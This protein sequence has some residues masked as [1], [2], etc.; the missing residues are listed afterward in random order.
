MSRN[1]YELSRQGKLWTCYK[2]VTPASWLCQTSYAANG[3]TPSLIL[4]K[5]VAAGTGN[6]TAP[7]RLDISQTGTVAGG[8]ITCVIKTD[9]IDRLSGTTG[10]LWSMG[11]RRRNILVGVQP[12]FTLRDGATA[13]AE[14]AGGADPR[15]IFEGTIFQTVTG[16]GTNWVYDFDE[17]DQLD[18]VGSI[19]VYFYASGTAPTMQG[20]LTVL[21]MNH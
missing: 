11:N 10:N 8:L 2:S 19:L 14:N 9:T 13:T 18:D 21:E 7:V 4:R 20:T 17:A 15:T 1:L 6:H 5:S 12:Q 3:T 16:L